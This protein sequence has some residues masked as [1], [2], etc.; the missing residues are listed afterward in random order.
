M[1]IDSDDFISTNTLEI[2]N[3]KIN[4]TKS[5]IIVFNYIA[6]YKNKKENISTFNKNIENIEKKYLLSIP[7]ACNK[8]FKRNIFKNENFIEGI[9][10]EDLATI[11][12]L[13][14]Y[15]KNISFIENYL[16]YYNVRENSI[17]NKTTYN[18]KMD[19]IFYVTNLLKKELENKYKDE[20]EFIFIEHLLRNAGI[21]FINYGKYD[22]IK[23]ITNIM[24]KNFPDWRKNIY[25]KKY[26]NTKQKVLSYLIYKR[27]FFIISLLR[28]K[29]GKNN[30]E[31]DTNR[32]S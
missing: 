11:P 18:K 21:R 15:T 26:Y 24:K 3:K 27:I 29:V 22:K 13:I 16:Y 10:Y 25:Y 19:D 12:R 23:E 7:S 20:I 31:K 9:Y 17:T 1:F 14:K 8:V 6:V 2:L 30:E 28:C 5:D 32:H 4:E